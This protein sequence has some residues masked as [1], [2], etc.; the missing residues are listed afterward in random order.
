MRNNN[1][2]MHQYTPSTATMLPPTNDLH[3]VSFE[4][5]KNH[6][7]QYYDLDNNQNY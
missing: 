5:E 1:T 6:H 3:L 4:E 2:R 7:L